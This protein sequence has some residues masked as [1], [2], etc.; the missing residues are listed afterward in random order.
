MARSFDAAGTMTSMPASPSYTPKSVSVGL[1]QNFAWD[2][3]GSITAQYVER[4]PKPA[5]LFSGGGHDATVTFDKGNPNLKIEAAQSIEIGLRRAKGPF[6]FEAT[7][8]QSRFNGFIFRRLT[9]DTC[10]GDTGVC[11]PGA[12]DLN[13]AIYSQADAVFRGGE[14]QSQWDVLPV[15][16]GFFGIED[17][18]DIVRAKFTDGSNVPRIPPA[19][20]GGGLFWRDNHWFARVRLLHAFPQN[21]I[22]PVAETTTPGY[23]DLRAEV[24]YTWKP[25]KPRADELS[26]MTLGISGTNLLN[27]DIR[28]SVSYSKDEVL[29]PGAGVRLF[30]TA[31]Y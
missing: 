6:R 25:G 23:D 9:G 30:V 7:A 12:G 8:Y 19:R 29:M 16:G 15:G 21:D 22:A 2:L 20:V 31:R 5:E 10:D 24:S 18:F 11:G 28:N 3:V 14:F 27:R 17:Q 1:I 26:E 4:A 13:E